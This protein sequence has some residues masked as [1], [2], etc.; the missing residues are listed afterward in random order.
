MPKRTDYISKEDMYMAAALLMAKRSKDPNSQIGSV[1]VNEDGIIVGMGYNGFP[2]GCSDD[3]FPW[4]R[5]IEKLGL[6]NTKYPYVVHAEKNA[7]LNKNVVSLKG[8]KM[9]NSLASCC[10]CAGPIIQVGIKEV[11]FF[12][13]KHHNEPE[14]VAARR[15]FKAAGVRQRQYKGKLGSI[16]LI[17]NR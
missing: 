13:D 17:F 11:I 9:Y 6:L 14:Y 5:D 1:I 2:R 4:E 15:M 7:I 12:N 10:Y 8:C 16:D 3:K